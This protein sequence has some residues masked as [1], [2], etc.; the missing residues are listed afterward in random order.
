MDG[1]VA[2]VHD[3]AYSDKVSF[4]IGPGGP[5]VAASAPTFTPL[6][7]MNLIMDS[8]L[9]P[10]VMGKEY[11]HTFNA[12]GGGPIGISA[13]V[14]ALKKE[15][16]DIK[17]VVNVEPDDGG[18][19]YVVPVLKQIL[20]DNGLTLVDTI[21]Y[22]NDQVDFNPIAVKIHAVKADA[23]I[24]PAGIATHVGNILKG[25]RALGDTRPY[26]SVATASGS[27][28]SAVAGADAATN[29]ITLFWELNAPGN[30][31][32]LDAIGNQLRA[33]YGPNNVMFLH[34]ASCLYTL[35]KVIQA[36]NSLEVKDVE[37]AWVNA[38]TIDTLFG[39][40]IPSGDLTYGIHNHCLTHPECYEI[41]KNGKTTFGAW[42][43]L[44]P[45]P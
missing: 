9:T 43:T 23:V 5:F 44:P 40:G 13:I 42:L 28:I 30:P 17:T 41:T 18:I 26:G 20:A 19:P 4:V 8:P 39:P 6:G 24:Q 27:D 11:P 38:K 37:A 1:N 2:A 21:A 32:V 34:D 14:M 33:K 35:V 25:L 12:F 29:L 31:A 3:L 45:V 16:P 22:N 7:I 15:F 36:A 10:G